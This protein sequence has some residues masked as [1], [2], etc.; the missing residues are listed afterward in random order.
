MSLGVDFR[1]AP[2]GPVRLEPAG[3]AHDPEA[4]KDEKHQGDECQNGH[5]D[6]QEGQSDGADVFCGGDDGGGCS[7]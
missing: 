7:C 1:T 5:E 3:F 2:G 4:G 6:R